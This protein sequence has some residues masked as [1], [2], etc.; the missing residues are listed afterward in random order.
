MPDPKRL[1]VVLDLDQTLISAEDWDTEDFNNNK[2]K[3][4]KFEFHDMD[5]Y[6]IVFERP[7]LQ[8]FL[9]YLFANFNVSVWTAASKDYALFIVD[10]ILLTKPN[11]HLDWI[12]FSYHCDLSKKKKDGSKDLS[13]FWDEYKLV[14][15]NKDNTVI[16]D[17]YDEVY[18]TQPHNCIIA[19]PFEFTAKNSENDTYLKDLQRLLSTMQQGKPA[20]SVNSSLG[21]PELDPE[22]LKK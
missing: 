13:M 7:N 14:G 5:G 16:I 1:N 3:A 6:Y 20:K 19:V 17:D 11:R 10:K 8:S 2:A 22:P 9:D 4:K 18:E 12:F 15:Y 21:L